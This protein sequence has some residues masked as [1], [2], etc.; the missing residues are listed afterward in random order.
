[1]V[2]PRWTSPNQTEGSFASCYAHLLPGDDS[3]AFDQ[4]FDAYFFE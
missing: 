4:A 1:M 3:A 2:A